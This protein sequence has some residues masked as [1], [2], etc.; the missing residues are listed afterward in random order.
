MLKKLTIILVITALFPSSAQASDPWTKQDIYRELT[1]SLIVAVDIEQTKS[2]V[3][4]GYREMNPVLGVAPS[5]ARINESA[6]TGLLVHVLIS[7][8]LSSENRPKFQNIS[9]VFHLGVISRNHMV[10]ARINF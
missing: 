4:E 8:Y 9:I 2:A 6:G 3:S 10:G 1:Y 5:N 7:N